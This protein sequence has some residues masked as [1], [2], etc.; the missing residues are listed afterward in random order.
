MKKIVLLFVGVLALISCE[1][2]NKTEF[3]KEALENKM[4]SKENVV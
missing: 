4:V 1:A 3:T 2:Q